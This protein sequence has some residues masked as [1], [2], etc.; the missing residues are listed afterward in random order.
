MPRRPTG[1]G[2]SRSAETSKY[3]TAGHAKKHNNTTVA[4]HD[5]KKPAKKK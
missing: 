4:E 5:R 2:K 1:K 3:V